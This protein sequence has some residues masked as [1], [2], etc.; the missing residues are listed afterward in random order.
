MMH[1]DAMPSS[2]HRDSIA[3]ELELLHMQRP[4]RL[5]DLPSIDLPA[6]PRRSHDMTMAE[7]ARLLTA[8]ELP[9]ESRRRSSVASSS[10][11]FSVSRAGTA[12]LHY[13]RDGGLLSPARRQALQLY[14][15]QRQQHA[16]TELNRWKRRASLMSYDRRGSHWSV[17]ASSSVGTAVMGSS[18]PPDNATPLARRRSLSMSSVESFVFGTRKP[19]DDKHQPSTSAGQ[20]QATSGTASCVSLPSHPFIT[21]F[22]SADTATSSHDHRRSSPSQLTSSTTSTRTPSRAAASSGTSAIATTRS[23]ATTSTTTTTTASPS[24]PHTPPTPTAATNYVPPHIKRRRGALTENQMMRDAA[25]LSMSTSDV[26]PSPARD[27]Q[28]NSSNLIHFGSDDDDDDDE[29]T[30]TTSS[31][32]SSD[33]SSKIGRASCRER[34]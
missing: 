22:R 7:T 19:D 9:E 26:S 10:W 21:V 18:Y 32:T 6:A 15:L 31:T 4:Y 14:Q 28:S 1:V 3:L 11:S 8:M 17:S 16:A 12:E 13:D 25:H 27:D 2:P 20:S 34:V 24:T 30:T 33:S 5:D 29:H 23:T